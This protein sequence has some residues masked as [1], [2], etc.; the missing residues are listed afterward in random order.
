MKRAMFL[1]AVTAA[2]TSA[3]VPSKQ[4]QDLKAKQE[5]CEEERQ[6]LL[7]EKRTL[8][9]S[10]DELSAENAKLDR[11]IT[12]LKEDTTRMGKSYR[13]ALSQYDKINE[14]N[15][16]LIAKQS[17]L[18]QQG[19]EEN[20]K[21]LEALQGTQLDLQKREDELRK[22]EAELNRKKQNLDMLS[23][24]LAQREARVKELEE[25]IAQKDEAVKQLKDRIAAAL[26][27][28][29]DKGLTVEQKNGKIYVSLEA[30][31][32]FASGS[33]KVN[34][35]GKKALIDLSAVIKDEQD[36]TILVEGHT[37]T[38]PFNGSGAIKDNWDL[39]VM[40]ATSVVRIMT[41]EGK[42]PSQMLTAA[43]RGEHVPVAD[44]SS[45]DGKAKNRR[46]EIILTPN[47]DQL[48]EIINE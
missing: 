10:N 14:L 30:K 43:G 6:Q 44:N 12:A 5:V 9:A 35:D 3:C 45:R 39:S 28:F 27:G 24:E 32:L 33:T 36:I 7:N 2:L 22:L 13:A 38:D 4:F 1:L 41:D 8:S 26:L 34:P 21:L 20:R 31:L 37:D 25:I 23:A 18:R 11:E 16:Q 42:V 29:K 19:T 17:A 15:E 46:I 48:F 40:R 47:L